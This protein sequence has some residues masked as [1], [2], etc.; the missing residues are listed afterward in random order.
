MVTQEA[1]T[2]ILTQLR[3]GPHWQVVIHPG[4]FEGQR[5][6]SLSECWNIME[7]AAVAW[8]HPEYP[9]I[10][11]EDER[12]EGEDWIASSINYGVQREYWRLYRSGQ[13]IQWRGLWLERREDEQALSRFAELHP[14]APTP[15]GYVDYTTLLR[16]PLEIFTFAG[17]L[18][19]AQ[20][21]DYSPVIEI[22]M[23]GLE[24]RVMFTV[25]P[26]RGES[27]DIHSAKGD[28]FAHSWTASLLDLISSPEGLAANA[29]L[30]LL[31][32][33]DYV[34]TSEDGIKREQ[35][36]FLDSL[37]VRR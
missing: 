24:G 12:E 11:W 7:R 18:G 21:L 4:K 13:F 5:I 28:T 23:N 29:T 25:D 22:A 2:D 19:V 9:I 15:H 30:R 32:H 31:E 27:R 16:T 34:S 14:L 20:A 1:S 36:K 33:F 6:S 26:W 35:Q 17:R 8:G 10:G 37:G 3:S